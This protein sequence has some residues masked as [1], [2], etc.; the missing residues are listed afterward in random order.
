MRQGFF[1]LVVATGLA[2]C[3]AGRDIAGVAPAGSATGAGGAG[4]SGVGGFGIGGAS[5]GACKVTDEALDAPPACKEKA[6]PDSFSPVVQWEWTAPLDGI[7]HYGSIVI[8]LVGNFTDDNGDGS[9]DLCDVPDV[10]VTVSDQLISSEN[11]GAP[12]TIYMLAGDTGALELTFSAKVNLEITPAFGDIDGDGL[13]EVIAATASEADPRL[14]AFEHDGTVKWIG[15]DKGGW[16]ANE[17]LNCSSIALYDLEGDGAVEIL[18]GFEVFDA[19]GKRKWGIPGNG[20]EFA[21]ASYFCPTTTAADLDDDGTLEVVFGHA[22][23]RADGTLLWQVPGN[24]GHPHVANFD[25]DPEPEIFLTTDEG[26]RVIEANGAVKFGPVRP[27]SPEIN[28]QCWCK[29]GA[30]HDFDGDGKAN[31]AA[32]SCTDYS[33][34]EIGAT[35]TPKWTQPIIDESGIATGT[36]FDFLGDGVADAIYGDENFAY[37]FEGITGEI[38]LKVQ[39]ISATIVEYPVVADVD[40]DGSAEIVITSNFGYGPTVQVIKDADDRWIPAR[41][42]WNQHAYHVTNVREDGVIPKTMGKSWKLLNTFRT[43]SQ[44][45]SKIDCAPEPPK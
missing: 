23:Y 36:A 30:V 19:S 20:A 9:I 32:G 31:V 37:A 27:T 40:N 28:V 5:G 10:L 11:P 8:P 29:P 6:P 12:A 3:A 16:M 41:R 2:A 45:E 35:A 18:I 25:D 22:A 26:L 21:V 1:V 39:R 14:I 4:G 24:P 13:P 17:S 38:E 43:N 34:Y 42:I 7:Y 15:P 44:V 33:V